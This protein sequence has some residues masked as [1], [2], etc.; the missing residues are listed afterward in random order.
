MD[1]RSLNLI[2]IG[3]GL[4]VFS[5]LVLP[6]LDL[7]PYLTASLAFALLGAIG[8]DTFLADG[9]VTRAIRDRLTGRSPDRQERIL[10]HEAGHFLMAHLFEIP[11]EGYALDA[12]ESLR[13]GQPGDGGVR[14][15][16]ESSFR[17]QV[18]TLDRG[19][20]PSAVSP[21]ATISRRWVDRAAMVLMAGIAAEELFYE[22]AIGGE[23]DRAQLQS[24]LRVLKFAPLAGQQRERW[25]IVQAKSTLDLHRDA[26]DA[27]VE[28]MGERASVTDCQGAIDAHPA[29][30]AEDTDATAA[31]PSSTDAT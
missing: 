26:Y 4:F 25:A 1:N 21:E 12:W 27:L 18:A 6:V 8:L 23:N 10:R 15:D 9:Q 28:A 31:T 5:S 2:A 24:M 14:F 16:L 20:V 13:Q 11:I 7:S 3:V 19:G 29:S 22:R 30:E 17:E